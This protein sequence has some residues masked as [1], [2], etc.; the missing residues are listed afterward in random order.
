MSIRG[1]VRALRSSVRDPEV[2]PMIFDGFHFQNDSAC[3]ETAKNQ[4]GQ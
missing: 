4:E 1:Y 2:K 3:R